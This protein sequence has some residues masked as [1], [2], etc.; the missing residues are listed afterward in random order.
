LQ[1]LT[2]IFIV[3]LIAVI[4]GAVVGAVSSVPITNALLE[5]QVS[6]Q[7]SQT[8]QVEEN[9]GRGGMDSQPDMQNGGGDNN[10][11]EKPDDSDS[12]SETEKPDGNGFTNYITQVNS[13]TNLTVILQMAGI[14]IL[15]TL[16]SGAVSMLFIMRYEPLKILANRD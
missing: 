14:C 5:N 3:T 8:Q 1:F 15:L 13:A 9:F 2:E 4:I 10:T 16:I 6:S 11:P 12:G 7:T